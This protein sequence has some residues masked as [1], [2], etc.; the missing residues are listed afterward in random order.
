MGV[1]HVL[2]CTNGAKLGNASHIWIDNIEISESI[3]TKWVNP[4]HAAGLFLYPLKTSGNFG[5]LMFSRGIEKDQLYE[6]G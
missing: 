2:K 4:F 3:I 6:M 5:F 1:F